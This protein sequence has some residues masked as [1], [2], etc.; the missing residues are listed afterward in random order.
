MARLCKVLSHVTTIYK[1]VY[2]TGG[3]SYN[4]V[5]M[6]VCVCSGMTYGAIPLPLRYSQLYYHGQYPGGGMCSHLHHDVHLLDCR[7]EKNNNSLLYYYIIISV[8][9]MY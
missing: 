6:S 2:N 1:L 3:S 7:R 4:T 8:I 5:F 9:H